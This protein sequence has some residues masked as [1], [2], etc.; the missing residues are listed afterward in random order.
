MPSRREGAGSG[1]GF[2]PCCVVAFSHWWAALFELPHADH[3]LPAAPH[4]DLRRGPLTFGLTSKACWGTG[5]VLWG[6]SW[7][8]CLAARLPTQSW[9]QA[10]LSLQSERCLLSLLVSR[11]SAYF[12]VL[13]GLGGAV[14]QEDGQP[15][16][17]PCK[18]GIVVHTAECPLLGHLAWCQHL[19]LTPVPGVE[20]QTL[21]NA[22]S[23]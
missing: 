1:A 5:R 15:L 2:P 10:G 11:L 23:T 4:A 8:G 14:S 12:N 19:G 20:S 7:P 18:D 6:A 13:T 16:P 22:P 9:K 17:V 21:P 3:R